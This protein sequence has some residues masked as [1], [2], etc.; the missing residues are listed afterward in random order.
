M[1]VGGWILLLVWS[2]TALGSEV[3][4]PLK[5]M[6]LEVGF[7]RYAFLNV[8]RNDAEAA[9][10]AF[11]HAVGQQRGYDVTA[12]VR[13][14][15][16]LPEFEAAVK[17]GTIDLAII[18]SW[19]YLAMDIQKLVTPRFITADRGRSGKRYVLLT[20]E[21]SDLKT[22]ADLRGKGIVQIEVT[23]SN[24]G[25][26]WLE[27]LL[28]EHR[29]GTPQA[30]FG[31]VESV[32]KPSAAVLPVFFG[33]KAVCLVDE[34]GFEIMK[35]L[36][37]QVGKGV[38]VM[39]ASEPLADALICLRSS[40]WTSEKFKR[41]VIEILGELHLEPSGQQILTLFKVSQLLPFEESQLETVRKLRAR[42]EKLRGE[43]ER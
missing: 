39:M 29:L 8:N 23:N 2:G 10:K 20:R 6:P 9:F 21:G 35:E 4:S 36:N 27:T 30:F 24:V 11:L 19:R 7:T 1:L 31:R 42:H 13:V 26:P 15:D 17:A 32:G 5:R 41:D 28:M 16:G 25:R 3:G 33:T 12:N 18:D 14:F 37:P 40:S 22:L 38:R 34:P 43:T